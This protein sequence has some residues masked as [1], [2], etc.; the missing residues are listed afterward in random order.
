MFVLQD[1]SDRTMS[2]K[3]EFHYSRVIIH[4]RLTCVISLTATSLFVAVA[5]ASVV[6]WF[7]FTGAPVIAND[8]SLLM[9]SAHMLVLP[10]TCLTRLIRSAFIFLPSNGLPKSQLMVCMIYLLKQSLTVC[11]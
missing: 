5:K 1:F 9:G 7:G 8:H 4:I 11:S 10:M 3:V 6:R 2:L